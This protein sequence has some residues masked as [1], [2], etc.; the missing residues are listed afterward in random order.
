[1]PCPSCGSDLPPVADS[2]AECGAPSEELSANWRQ[3]PSRVPS[4][5]GFGD[6]P[7]PL[8]FGLLV[9]TAVGNLAF[10]A[11]FRASPSPVYWTIIAVAQV[12]WLAATGLFLWILLRRR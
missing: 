2:C 7:R 12:A 9:F 6:L 8:V 4:R 5:R 1:M 10:L 3:P 11:S